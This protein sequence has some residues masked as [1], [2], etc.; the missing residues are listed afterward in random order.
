MQASSGPD[1]TT[2]GE[3]GKMGKSFWVDRRQ[4]LEYTSPKIKARSFEN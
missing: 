4:E 3:D 1:R 2:R